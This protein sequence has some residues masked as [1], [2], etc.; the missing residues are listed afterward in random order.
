MKEFRYIWVGGLA[1]T[2]LIIFLPIF[3]FVSGEPEKANDP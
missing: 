2:A 3:L 1:A